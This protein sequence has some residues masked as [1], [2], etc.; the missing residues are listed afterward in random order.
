LRK[1]SE[2][3]ALILTGCRR[4]RR[5]GGGDRAMILKKQRRK[6]SVWAVLGHEKKRRGVGRGGDGGQRGS[7]FM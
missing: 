5:M 2:G 7:P 6:R 3:M 4:G 1:K